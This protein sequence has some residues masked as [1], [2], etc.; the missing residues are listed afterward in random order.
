MK[1]VESEEG[2]C[3]V[4]SE[5]EIERSTGEERRKERAR[6]LAL[7]AVQIYLSFQKMDK[8]LKVTENGQMTPYSHSQEGS[9][10]CIRAKNF[11]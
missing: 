8:F 7:T 3:K 11:A 10:S 5:V 6:A 4:R 2:G 9:N 1:R